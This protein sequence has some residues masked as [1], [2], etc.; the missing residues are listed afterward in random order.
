MIQ[1]LFYFV[2][3]R[4]KKLSDP[5]EWVRINENTGSITIFRN[6][7]REAEMIRGGI[8]NITIL[9]SDKGKNFVSKPATSVS[10]YFHPQF[11]SQPH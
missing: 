7:D 11:L 1:L 4:Y 5:K 6:L 8:Y 3:N 10:P 2:I 9:A